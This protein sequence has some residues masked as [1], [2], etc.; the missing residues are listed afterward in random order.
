MPFLP[1]QGQRSCHTGFRKTSG[2]TLPVGYMTANNVMSVISS[3]ANVADDAETV[4]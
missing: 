3:N 2:W 1:L 4:S